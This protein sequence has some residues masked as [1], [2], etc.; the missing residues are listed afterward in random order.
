MSRFIGLAAVAAFFMT[1]GSALA[2]DCRYSSCTYDEYQAFQQ[3][4]KFEDRMKASEKENF[5]LSC[6]NWRS[7][8]DM[9]D[10]SR[11]SS[12]QRDTMDAMR[13]KCEARGA[14]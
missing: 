9:Q 14:W 10:R 2:K 11:Q 4:L 6:M 5:R 12:A 3:Q 8:Y 1:G 7:I 13:S